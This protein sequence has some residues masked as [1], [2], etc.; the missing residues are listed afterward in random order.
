MMAPKALATTNLYR[1]LAA[2]VLAGAVM[3]EAFGYTADELRKFCNA[4]IRCNNKPSACNLK[5]IAVTPACPALRYES[6]APDVLAMMSV[7]ILSW[8][9]LDGRERS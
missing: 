3:S 6:T 7:G 4:A 2:I 9:K 1:L 5:D 8:N